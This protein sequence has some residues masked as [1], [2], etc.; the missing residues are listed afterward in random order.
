MNVTERIL[1]E[2]DDGYRTFQCRLMPTV[3]PS[4]V[5]GVR[6]PVLRRMAKELSW[7]EAERFMS[8]LPH[9]YYEENNLHAFL[10]ERIRDFDECIAALER[11]LP[12]LDNWATCD[13]MMPHVLKSDKKR[14]LIFIRRWLAHEN[15]YAVRYVIG[16]LMKLYLDEDFD[17]SYPEEVVSIDK[18]Y[19]GHY[20]VKMMISWYFA[21]ALSKQYGA[22]V[23][24]I[25]SGELD[26]FVRTMTIRKACESFR[27][28]EEHKRYLRSF[29]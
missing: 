5:I 29:L 2:R 28:S 20:Y 14:L 22:V 17:V 8:C 1:N 25:E 19:Y 23:R 6:T 7:D 15:P 3:D 24:Y 18:K 4:L 21:T 11:F 12:Y 9:T 26:S 16:L 10:I 27:V 13:S